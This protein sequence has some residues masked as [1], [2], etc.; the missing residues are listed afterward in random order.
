MSSFFERVK[1]AVIVVD[2]RTRQIVLWN[3]AAERVFGYSTVEALELCVEALVPEYLK[4]R[5]REGMA[6]YTKTGRGSYID[7]QELLEVPALRKGG[8]E[9]Y[10]ELSLSPIGAVDDGSDDGRFVVGIV[11]DITDRKLAEE[12]LFQ[13]EERYRLL[14]DL[15]PE[16]IAVHNEGKIVYANAAGA[17]LLGASKAEELIGRSLSDF[18]HP[19]Y[20][21]R[22]EA[23]VR[24]TQEEGKPTDLTEIKMVRLGGEIID[25]EIRGMPIAYGRLPA[26]QI[27]LRNIT[28]HKRAE[29]ALRRSEELL[30]TGI[31]NV[32]IVLFTLDREGVFTL[33]EG[34][35]LKVLG[36]EP[37]EVVGRS[38]FE[39]YRDIP[40]VLENVSRALA[41][42]TLQV[43]TNVAGLV[44]DTWYSP[45]RGENGEVVGLV[46]VA[47]DITER[48]QIEEARSQLVAI[49]DSSDD[50]II[51]KNLEGVITSWNSGAQKL[52]GYSAEEVVG[53]SISILVPRDR[54]DEVA[55]ILER[56]R[57]GE[58]VDHYET[59]RT[60]RDGE[61]LHVSITVSPFRDSAGNIAGAST[62][63]RDITGRKRAER[64]LQEA[65]RSLSELVNLRSDFTA[66]V[67]HEIS[68]PLA[69][70]RMFLEVLATGELEPAEQ[71]DTLAKIRAEIDRL[72][73]L[74]ADIRSAAAIEREEFTLMPRQTSTS[75]LLE[76]A[77]RFAET[78]PGDHPLIVE[79]SAEEQVWADS[80]RI[81]QVLRNLLSNAAKYSPKGA[82]IELRAMQ[83][84]SHDQVR[85]EVVDHGVGVH[86]EDVERI[87]KKFGRGRD[88]SARK[89]YG[90]GLGLYL[91]RRIVRAHGSD[92]RLAP[93]PGGGSVF[94][95]ELEVV[96]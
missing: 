90:V 25:V 15:S 18:V 50:A 29:E 13:S 44:F 43:E 30:R 38:I 59:V 26:T 69:T 82:P 77:A 85:I 58:S 67:A 35:G 96:R 32:P 56:V 73:T 3:A 79:A 41:G 76:D 40:Q 6:R 68:S 1:D 2:T 94:G 71:A 46:G 54:L 88:R 93:A 62:I 34:N 55:T 89:T 84:K 53:R 45:L 21:E 65:N 80:Y 74:V 14:V 37:G 72:S 9:I 63:A 87:F 11:R 42:E 60:R 92:L 33:S 48:K 8:E 17:R 31:G 75:E 22:V 7:S 66:M 86:P 78:L 27:V 16:T 4:A 81:G 64:E 47:F 19:D 70:I 61:H 28:E 12:A 24:Q 36:R 57:R 23:W 49:V 20:V 95:F 39:V 10:I 51:G 83:G 91:S 52:Y 5:H